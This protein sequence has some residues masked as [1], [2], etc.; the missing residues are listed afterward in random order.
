M[1]LPQTKIY[2]K[3]YTIPGSEQT[4]Y[5]EKNQYPGL[6]YIFLLLDGIAHVYPKYFL[7]SPGISF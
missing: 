6:M 5:F 4:D 7:F 1:A 2:S 3:I